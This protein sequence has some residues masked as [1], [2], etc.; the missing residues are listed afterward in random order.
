MT[1]TAGAASALAKKALN[2]SAIRARIAGFRS[3]NSASVSRNRSSAVR[4]A[5]AVPNN[6]AARIRVA[7]SCVSPRHVAASR[8]IAAAASAGVSRPAASRTSIARAPARTWS[9]WSR[10]A[11][12]ASRAA[13]AASVCPARS[14]CSARANPSRGRSGNA[15][16]E[17]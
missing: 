9:N 10:P 8:F 6:S 12:S 15:A 7:A 14:N 3:G 4:H 16:A 11:A 1:S 17:G 13:S 5:P 2:T